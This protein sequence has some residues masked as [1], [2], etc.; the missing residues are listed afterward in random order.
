MKRATF[1]K[2]ALVD[3]K[4]WPLDGRQATSAMHSTI[5]V[6]LWNRLSDFICR[7][8]RPSRY[9]STKT[10]S[11]I[12]KK[13]GVQGS[14]TRELCASSG[15]EGPPFPILQLP[16]ELILIIASELPICSQA[17]LSL[18]CRALWLVLPIQFRKLRMPAEQPLNLRDPTM[19]K[20]QFYQPDRW[21]FLRLLER[22]MLK[23]WYLCS[24]CIMLH[25]LQP[26]VGYKNSS[27]HQPESVIEETRAPFDE[28]RSHKTG[29]HIAAG[30]IDLCPCMKLTASKRRKIIANLEEAA[31]EE[32]LWGCPPWESINLSRPAYRPPW[33]HE[34]RHIYDDVNVW[35]KIGVFLYRDGGD[36]GIIQKYNFSYQTGSPNRSPRLSCPHQNL[37]EAIRELLRCR[38]VH[39]ERFVCVKCKDVQCCPDC[40]TKICELTRNSGSNEVWTT[41]SFEVERRLDDKTWCYQT[42]FPFAKSRIPTER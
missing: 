16:G 39:P 18:T 6:S 5:D 29:S 25:P 15:M 28:P 10:A 9:G 22:D 7:F 20:P 31:R 14:L 17:A 35:T 38:D 37:D 19:S 36:L 2:A 34:C 23:H 24:E 27:Q 33:V 40:G 41:C 13:Q 8:F 3:S 1:K 12:S 42:V 21:D 11:S 30:I 26:S 4:F 32:K